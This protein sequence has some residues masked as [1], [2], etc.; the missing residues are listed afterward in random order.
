MKRLKRVFIIGLLVA[1]A[2]SGIWVLLANNL[3]KQTDIA[4]ENL[5]RSGIGIETSTIALGNF[6]FTPRV[7]LSCKLAPPG[8][9][10]EIPDLTLYSFL[11]PGLPFTAAITQPPILENAD[12]APLLRLLESL[13]Q[14]RLTV[15]LP[16]R[17][18]HDTYRETLEDWRVAGGALEIREAFA[19]LST[20]TR[21]SGKGRFDLDAFLNPQGALDLVLTDPQA[22]SATL[23][24]AGL[25]KPDHAVIAGAVIG[26]MARPDPKTAQP[27]MTIDLT[28]SDRV[29]TLGP[30]KI[31]QLPQAAW[32]LRPRPLDK[33][34]SPD[35]RQ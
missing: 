22:L 7:Q 18:P 21:L 32:P 8:M 31:A 5:R 12:V 13:S 23:V 25:M 35:P 6:P 33:H 19:V 24:K 2:Y 17:W 15:V 26:A 9:Q 4:I 27:T 14:A 3:R 28:L 16:V 30:L 20:G 29:L 34:S 10:I 1:S 11:I